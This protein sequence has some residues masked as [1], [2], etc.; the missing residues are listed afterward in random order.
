MTMKDFAFQGKIY[1]GENVNGQPRNLKW[2]GDQSSLNFAMSIEKEERKENWSGNKGVSVVNIQSKAVSPELVLRELT[3][4]NILL[5][6]HGKLKKVEAGSVTAEQL[7]TDLIKDELIL[8]AK[9]TISNLVITDST[10]ATPKTLVDGT[11]YAIEST[12]SGLIKLLN[13]AAPL[14]QPFK[15]AYSHGGM[16]S[17]SMLN[18]QPPVR[19]LYMEAINTVDGRRARVHLYKVQFDPMAQLPLTSQTLSEFTLNGATLIDAI[20]TLD[21]DLG[22]YGKIEWL[23]KE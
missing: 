4:D 14:T 11:D 2:V 18:A 10:A 6:V 20:N 21:D 15:A 5:G 12:H 17:I 3:P 19:Y 22:G 1:L 16:I 8:L 23:D 7:P 9:G 13:V